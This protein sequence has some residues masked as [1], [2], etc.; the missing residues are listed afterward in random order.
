MVLI[1]SFLFVCLCLLLNNART[2]L[3]LKQPTNAALAIFECYNLA[4]LAS[5]AKEL[6]NLAAKIICFATEKICLAT[7]TKEI[8]FV[9]ETKRLGTEPFDY[10]LQ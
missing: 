4:S 7:E 8:C 1:V 6:G 5:D 2:R 9:T 3:E 10:I